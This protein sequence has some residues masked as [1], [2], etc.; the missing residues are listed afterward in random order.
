MATLK[1]LEVAWSD[2][3]AAASLFKRNAEGWV[4]PRFV[5]QAKCFAM[6]AASTGAANQ[7][8]RE[9]AKTARVIITE[10][11]YKKVSGESDLISMPIKIGNSTNLMV[12]R[13]CLLPIDADNMLDTSGKQAAAQKRK[14]TGQFHSRLNLPLMQTI[15]EQVRQ[16]GENYARFLQSQEQA[17]NLKRFRIGNYLLLM[18]L[19]SSSHTLERNLKD[20]I[21]QV[22]LD[23]P[24]SDDLLMHAARAFYVVAKRSILERRS[25]WEKVVSPEQATP[26][27][28]SSAT[29]HTEKV[30]T[31]EQATPSPP[32]SATPHTETVPIP[33]QTTLLA[34]PNEAVVEIVTEEAAHAPL[35]EN[36]SP[37]GQSHEADPSA[38]SGEQSVPTESNKPSDLIKQKKNIHAW[39]SW[40]PAPS[41]FDSVPLKGNLDDL[42]MSVETKALKPK[43]DRLIPLVRAGVIWVQKHGK[44]HYSLFFRT[45]EERKKA[46]TRLRAYRASSKSEEQMDQTGPNQPPNTPEQT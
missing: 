15:K 23:V 1:D 24:S 33:D 18:C 35:L 21:V 42:S 32:S 40:D 22:F 14:M 44:G 25:S 5:D 39:Q 8:Y 2:L 45:S 37:S 13:P 12:P 4:R 46:A 16:L 9:A 17:A 19:V 27:P 26:S 30:S 10:R 36:T 34:N 29:P 6:T 28:P 3:E 31:P 11:R 38:N 20:E 7:L 41:N 43:P